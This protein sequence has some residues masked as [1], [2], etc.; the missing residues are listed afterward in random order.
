MANDY[1]G[2][3]IVLDTFTSAIDVCSSLGFETGTKLKVKQIEWQTPTSTAHTALITTKASGR[4]IFSEQCTTAN[5]SII[6]YDIG[7][8]DNLYIAISGIG[9]GK[10]LIYL[11]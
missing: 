3:P 1:T 9:S 5:Q 4:T 7:W 6:K 8:V 11:E 2:N 10:I